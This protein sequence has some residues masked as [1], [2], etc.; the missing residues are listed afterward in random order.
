MGFVV[1]FVVFEGD[2]WLEFDGDDVLVVIE[3]VGGLIVEV[4][5]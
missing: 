4:F 1:V 2:V 3:V 5:E